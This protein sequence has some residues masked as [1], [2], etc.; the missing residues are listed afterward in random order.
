MRTQVAAVVFSAN[1][2]LPQREMP[3]TSLGGRRRLSSH[4]T[5]PTS[6]A[7]LTDGS[8]GVLATTEN[9]EAAPLL[10]APSK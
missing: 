9:M 1:S 8:G 5:A 6:V 10:V 7:S 3:I 4:E 2:A